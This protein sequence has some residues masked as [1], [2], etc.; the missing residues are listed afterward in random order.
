MQLLVFI[1]EAKTVLACLHTVIIV[2]WNLEKFHVCVYMSLFS[3]YSIDLFWILDLLFSPLLFFLI[4]FRVL[5]GDGG[6]DV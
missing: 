6:K 2:F 1:G 4:F 3:S 5:K